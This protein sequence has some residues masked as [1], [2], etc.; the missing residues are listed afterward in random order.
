VSLEHII[1]DINPGSGFA[2]SADSTRLV[3][4]TSQPPSFIDIYSVVDSSA[5]HLLSLG[6]AELKDLAWAPSSQNIAV[7]IRLRNE[8]FYRLLLLN[9][10]GH[11]EYCQPEDGDVHSPVWISASNELDYLVQKDTNDSVLASRSCSGAKVIASQRAGSMRLQNDGYRHSE[12]PLIESGAF[13][14]PKLF[15]LKN[16]QMIAFN[17]KHEV[18][19]HRSIS[20]S[21]IWIHGSGHLIPVWL[22]AKSSSMPSDRAIVIVHGGPHLHESA[23]WDP[24]REA[25]AQ[26]GFTVLAVNYSGSTGYGAGFE[27]TTDADVQSSDLE[28]SIRYL[29]VS[30]GIKGEHIVVL[31]SSYGT[32]VLMHALRR[33]P[34]LCKMI[35]FSPFLGGRDGYI[36]PVPIEFTGTVLAFHGARDPISKPGAALYYI[37]LLFDHEALAH[38]FYWRIFDDEAHGF[39]RIDSLQEIYGTIICATNAACAVSL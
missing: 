7:S 33:H 19:F 28:A 21:Q 20:V 12:L 32:T 35:V 1:P 23:D 15:L 6:F 22:W 31:A 8:E 17:D 4:S 14:P 25:F 16:R 11:A 3:F 30:R 24:L 9:T 29:E 27:N 34:D 39:A 2:W 36:N 13:Q 26:S 10:N 37:G 18:H 5:T 38:R